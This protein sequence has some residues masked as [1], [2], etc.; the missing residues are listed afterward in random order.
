MWRHA[1]SAGG[2]YRSGSS[3]DGLS[4]ATAT[5]PS[6]TA[7]GLAIGA[8]RGRARARLFRLV[9][10]ESSTRLP[11]PRPR[12]PDDLR[13]YLPGVEPERQVTDWGRSERV[14]G[15]LDAT[16]SEFL[17]RYW[18]RVEVEGIE[19]VPDERRRAAGLQPLGRAAAGRADDRQGDQGG[20][21]PAAPGAP[22]DGALFQ[23]LS[24]ASACSLP[25]IGGVPAHPANVH[26]LLLDEHQLVLVFPEGR[27]GTEKL[28]K[29]RY[30]LR[31][32]GRGGFV[33]AA[34][35]A[36]VPDRAR[37]PWSA[38]RRR[39]RSSPTSTVLQRLTGL[40]YFPLTPTFPHFG[41]LGMFG[42]LPAKFS[43]R[44]LEPVPTDDRGATSPG[45][46]GRSCRRS[47]RTSARLIQE[48]LY[49]MLG[50]AALGLVRMSVAR[51]ILVTG[52]STYWGGRVAQ[53][54]ERDPAV[55]A[56]VGVD[57]RDPTV[58]LER[59]EYV[60]VGHQ[61]A[62][63]RRIVQAAEID[64]VVD[65]RLV[66]DSTTTPLAAR[67]RE[68]RHRHDEHPR[69]LQRPGVAR[70]ARSC[71]SPR[72]HWYGCEQDDPAY[73]TEEM[74]RPHP[75][76]TP[77]EK[78]HRRGRARRPRLRRRH[79]ARP[80]SPCC[81]SPTGWGPR[82]RPRTRACSRCPPCPPIFGFD[83]RYQFVHEDDIVGCL[84]FAVRNDLPGLYNCAGDGV[85]VLS[86]VV[87]LLGK[88]LL[89]ILPPWGTSIADRP[90]RPAGDPHPAGDAA[91]AAVRARARQPP[92]QGRRLRAI[93]TRRARRCRPT[94]R[95]CACARS[96]AAATRPTATSARWRSSCAAAR[97]CA[98]GP[99]RAGRRR[100]RAD[101]DSL[102][103]LDAAALIAL[104]P[105][106]PRSRS[107][108]RW[109]R[110]EAGNARRP[111]VL[112]AIGRNLARSRP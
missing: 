33:E 65:T 100:P 24:A 41:L 82:S 98:S 14:E 83:P 94:P 25:K 102:D 38:P 81:G 51:A 35:R 17:Y 29:D 47:P 77:I 56:I 66:V 39:C 43:I 55:E 20:A 68:Q 15:A 61:H 36:G 99:S 91:A 69:R 67:A 62:L 97:P 89:P 105:S 30:R 63:L 92:A 53:A 106:L 78:R 76:R 37:S 74:E 71:S 13:D 70:C 107:S 7:G 111:E 16:V 22:D 54:L 2:P 11:A 8:R 108:K 46:T 85:L 112:A 73:F 80:P 110:H 90:R 58:E 48:E 49:E 88:P 45:R 75:P 59:T 27:K 50:Q 64:T 42:Y 96:C 28:Y 57:V 3:C 52:L 21:R 19:N 87:D 72:A 10:V 23:G 104:L 93:A 31:R 84:E 26:R 4:A 18:F 109:A 32:F 60:R 6:L 12:D 34:M 1:E 95:R 9:T 40:L 44:F 101:V 103:G 79:A 5:P 86:E